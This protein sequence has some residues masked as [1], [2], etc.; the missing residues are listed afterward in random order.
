MQADRYQY[1][2]VIGEGG[3]ATVYKGLQKSLKRPVAIKVLA[4]SLSD[5]PDIKERFKR[6][7]LIIARLNH[8]NIVHVIDKGMTSQGRPVFVMEF[9]EGVN[10]AD[11]I[12]EGRFSF[13]EKVD[14]AVQLCKGLAYAHKLDVVHRDIKPANVIVDKEGFAKILDFGIASFFE[15][16]DGSDDQIVMG[17]DAYMAPEAQ[18]GLSA[19]TKLS[20]VYSVGVLLHELFGGELPSPS[21]PPLEQSDANI[22]QSLAD[23]VRACIEV[24]PKKR[25]QSLEDIKTRL[26]LA[27]KGQ[28]IAE[29]Q[30]NRAGQ[31]LASK[32]GLLDVMREDKQGAVYLFEDNVSHSLL[33]IKKRLA[34]EEGFKESKLLC[35]LKH[36]NIVNLLGATENG[37][38]FIVVMEYLSGG[39]LMDRLIG[40][41]QLNFFLKL[42]IQIS[43]GLSFAHQN[44]IIHGNLRPSNVM[45]T[46][47][48]RVKLA[49]FGFDDLQRLKQEDKNFYHDGSSERTEATDIFAL[50]AIFYHMLCGQPPQIKD[51]GRLVK[52]K[53]FMGLDDD[54]K[55][56]LQRMLSKNIKSR[57]PNVE[58]VISELLTLSSEQN[59]EVTASPQI[60]STYTSEPTVIREV[61]KSRA[62][63][64]VTALLAMS[65]A[66]NVVLLNIDVRELRQSVSA[67]LALVLG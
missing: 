39:S 51:D 29:E 61:K 41:M 35:S 31:G 16:K 58:V 25:P 3:M 28:H 54:L 14:V 23:L 48:M 37:N 63:W 7:S 47:D 65:L 60:T 64:G 30:A 55:D 18:Q 42:A 1:L 17:T 32:F 38:V 33:V 20:D 5:N 27:M 19:T 62:I 21:S 53:R 9:I 49:E 4:A 24:E 56:L 46:Q 22:T 40:P 45:F 6:E 50:G 67:F 11:A 13:N 59:T 66:L 57:P 52:P 8:P 2:D 15:N 34:A 36:P 43:R 44:R 12:R 26:L 10:L